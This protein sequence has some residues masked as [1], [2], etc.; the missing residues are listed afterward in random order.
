MMPDDVLLRLPDVT[1]RAGIS[2]S[3]VYEYVARGRFPAPVRVGARAVRWRAS[4]VSRWLE[5][6]TKT[7]EGPKNAVR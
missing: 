4:D 7:T 5:S 3:T 1:Q 6:L 2:R